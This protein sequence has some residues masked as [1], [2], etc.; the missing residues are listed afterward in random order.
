[1]SKDY[2]MTPKRSFEDAASWT[3]HNLEALKPEANAALAFIEKWGMVAGIPDGED[4][5]GRAR[6]RLATP[7]EVVDRAIAVAAGA[8]RAF[9]AHGWI[10]PIPSPE[11]AA[12]LLKK[13]DE[14]R[15]ANR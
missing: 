2:V 12:S 4:S 13:L 8:F 11:E 6:I 15:K 3:I 1:M 9:E 14:E 10:Q 7:E 5:A